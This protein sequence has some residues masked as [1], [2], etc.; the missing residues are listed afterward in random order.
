MKPVVYVTGHI[1]STTVG[2]KLARALGVT[3]R[4]VR[5]WRDDPEELPTMY[6]ILR[7][8]G[9]IIHH[10]WKTGKPFV[11]VDHGF[12]NPGHY[13]GYYRFV[14][15]ALY[16]TG[17]VSHYEERL[18]LL[19]VTIKRDREFDGDHVLL[20]RPTDHVGLFFDVDLDA[21]QNRAMSAIA[22]RTSLPI[23]VSI[24]G[25]G[26]ASDLPNAEFLVTAQSNLATDAIR[27]GVPVMRAP[28]P[29]S[30]AATP[31]LAEIA[32]DVFDPRSAPSGTPYPIRHLWLAGLANQQFRLDEKAE[33]RKWFEEICSIP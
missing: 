29:H 15:N 26:K 24:K 13:A 4:L 25:D 22:R 17:K 33:L 20:V 3:M 1:H 32:N 10:C 6:G 28:L 21:W 31:Y 8:T 18:N 14:L 9:E 5:D 12:I 30:G 7:G 16:A 27:L 2:L 19:N 23:R 11:Y